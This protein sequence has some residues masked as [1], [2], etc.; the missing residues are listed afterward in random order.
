MLVENYNSTCIVREVEIVK[1]QQLLERITLLP[2]RLAEEHDDNNV[3]A[4]VRCYDG[5][6]HCH[7]DQRFESFLPGRCEK[8]E[9]ARRIFN[10]ERR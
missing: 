2:F 4:V 3:E 7:D 9:L 1:D 10:N 5:V 8:P 6:D